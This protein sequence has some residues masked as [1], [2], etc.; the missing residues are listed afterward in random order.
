MNTF[1]NLLWVDMSLALIKTH[2][3]I[4]DSSRKH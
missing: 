1:P 2:T 4:Q 3:Y